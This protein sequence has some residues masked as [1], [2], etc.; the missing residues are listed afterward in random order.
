MRLLLYICLCS[1]VFAIARSQAVWNQG[2]LDASA[3]LLA[4]LFGSKGPL[5]Q[6]LADTV[7]DSR[8][9]NGTDISITA[10]P[11]ANISQQCQKDLAQYNADL[12]QGKMYALKM[13]DAGGKPPSGILGGNLAWTGSYYQCVNITRKGFNITFDGKFYMTT[14]VPVQQTTQGGG[15]LTVAVCVP[16]SCSQQDVI[17]RLDGG[18][19]WRALIQQGMLEV[20]SAVSQESLPIQNVTI[21]GICI[22]GVILLL[23]V[24]G[25][26]YD[27]TVHQPRMMATKGQKENDGTPLTPP[28]EE[29]SVATGI[30]GRIILSFSVYT[31]IG[32]LLSTKQAPGSIKCLNGIRFLSM[33][34]IILGHTYQIAIP[35]FDNSLQF[36]E[37]R[38]AFAFQAVN[39]SSVSVDSFFFISGLLMSYLLLKRIQKSKEDGKSVPYGMMYLH[40]YLRLTPTYMF[41]LMLYV[42]VIPPMFSGPTWSQ[43][44]N[45]LDADCPGWWWANPL[46]INNLINP[47]DVCMS[48]SWYLANDMQF[49]AI[50]V[51]LVYILYRWQIFGM[52]VQLAILLASFLTTA[53]ITLYF[54]MEAPLGDGRYYFRPYCRIGPYLVGL[55]VGWLMVKIKGKQTRSVTVSLLMILGWL[56]AA[57]SAV[58]VLYPTHGQYLGATLHTLSANA[59]YLTVHRTVWAMALAWVVVACHY[60]YGGVVN[61]ILSW[62]GW[63][64]LSRLTFCT[65]LMHVPVVFAFY[66]TMEVPIHYSTFT[67]IYFFLGHL[68]LSFGMGFLVSVAVESPLMGVEKVVFKK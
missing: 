29:T 23:L 15:E 9:E 5:Q 61:T 45:A 13:L 8:T 10:Q 21:A 7:R 20:T 48:W 2:V 30:A 38:Q 33:S 53:G 3:Q 50:G 16:S 57:A 58:A 37:A 39:N 64:P 46:Y 56:V 60:G 68:A 11:T 49:F 12:S 47:D 41:V 59:L 63:V 55:A 52:A 36:S 18:I 26:I 4:S 14:L 35:S 1:A 43:A 32:K 51:P 28:D 19:Y 24:I 27:V 42:W 6:N 65:Y 44:P 62:D 67:M 22:C 17:E 54:E 40:R 25:T 66:F 31:N 34:W